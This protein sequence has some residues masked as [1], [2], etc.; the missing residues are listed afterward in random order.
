[1]RRTVAPAAILAAALLLAGCSGKPP[2]IARSYARVIYVND[3][4]RAQKSETLGVY[5]VAS[6]PDGM[7]NLSAFYVIN[8]DAELF[9]KVDKTQWSSSTAEG[10][11]WIGASTLSMPGDSPLPAGQYRVVLQN[12][13][14]DTVEDTVTVP[15]RAASAL[16]ASYPSASA[17]DGEIA[18]TGS[19]ASYEIWV[20][21]ANGV[22]VAAFP[23]AGT[24]P[25]LPITTVTSSAA[26]LAGGFTFRVFSWDERAGYGVLSGPYLTGSLP[27]P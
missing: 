18:I 25:R 15:T 9:W 21:S 6:D 23:V 27:P 4:T 20:Y 7:E 19:A 5:L 11:S 14:G 16:Q 13:G 12:V 26:A 2:V 10:E 22:F 17:Q 1:M 8:D 3:V 24:S